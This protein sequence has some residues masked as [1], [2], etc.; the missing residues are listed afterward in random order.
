MDRTIEPT[1]TL[2]GTL[3][4][5]GDKSISHRALMLSAIAEGESRITGL[6]QGADVRSTAGCMR[7]LGVSLQ[8]EETEARVFGCGLRGLQAPSEPLDAGNSGTAM[9]LLLG[10][11]AG[12][13]FKSTLTG[14]DSLQRRPMSRVIRPLEA[15]G[16]EI[17][18]T[19]D[20]RA[21]L[22]IQGRGLTGIDYTLPVASAQVQSALLL[23]GLYA[24][25]TTHVSE[26]GPIRDHTERML[27]YLGVSLTREGGTV[28]LRGGQSLRAS[29]L[30]VPGDPSS[31][32]FWLAAGALVPGAEVAVGNV[33]TNPTRTGLFDAL[34]RMGATLS[35][36][37]ERVACRE[38]RADLRATGSRLRGIEVA[39]QLVPRLIDELPLLA[40]LAT[41]AEGET[42][43]RG[44]EELRVK[45]T[46]RVAAVSANLRAMGAELEERP[47]GWVIPGAQKLEGATV[48]S[49]GDHRVAMAFAVAAL[50]AQGPTTIRG[51][52][53]ADI[54]YP[55]FFEQLERLRG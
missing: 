29:E 14:D 31:A 26:P 32:A 13:R 9:R 22:T 44:A 48:E 41:Q 4:V 54:S 12:Q 7:A 49:F 53:W 10:L 28:A 24:D 1:R 11:L 19:G 51:A 18:T 27:A 42:V 50:V 16:A 34:A 38:P 43:V 17:E 5:P 25:G 20:G 45:E 36:E 15:M 35:F 30:D 46:D 6:S 52:E 2:R 23:A 47:D 37:R 21:P 40:V 39:G 33:C 55:G 8:V 3:T